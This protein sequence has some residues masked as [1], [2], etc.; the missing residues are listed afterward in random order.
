[1]RKLT[2]LTLFA[3]LSV[4]PALAVTAEDHYA[5]LHEKCGPSLKMKK[6]GCDC[7]VAAARRDLSESEL[8]MVVLYVKQD[9]PGIR[10]KQGE[11]NGNQMMTAMT[12]VAQVPRACRGK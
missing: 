4:S 10:K 11:L 2:T 5:Y 12:F 3:L 7:T 9:K 1:M 8:E 6:S